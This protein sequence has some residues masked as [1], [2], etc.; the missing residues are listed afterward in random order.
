MP[1]VRVTVPGPQ[2]PVD[3]RPTMLPHVLVVEGHGDDKDAWIEHPEGCPRY[4][5]WW[6]G[7]AEHANG[8]DPLTFRFDVET[9]G[10]YVEW[11]VRYCGLDSIEGDVDGLHIGGPGGWRHLPSGRYRLEPWFQPFY[12][13]GSN[14]VDADGGISLV[15]RE[16]PRWWDELRWRALRSRFH[17]GEQFFGVRIPRVGYVSVKGPKNTAYFSERNRINC[18]VWPLRG[19]WRIVRRP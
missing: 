3:E 11:E 1:P 6:P 18:D 16:N 8:D 14:P 10:C 17:V 19:G 15:G 5:E 2:W 13:A 4:C 9:Y 12:W 7:A